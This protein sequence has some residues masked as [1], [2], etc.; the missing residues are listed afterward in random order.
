MFNTYCLFF[1]RS[2]FPL[3]AAAARHRRGTAVH[4]VMSCSFLF[5][6]QLT[7]P[8]TISLMAQKTFCETPVAA[9][10]LAQVHRATTHDGR[11]VAVKVQYLDMHERFD[12]DFVTMIALMDAATYLFKE[13][14][15]GFV[16][17]SSLAVVNHRLHSLSITYS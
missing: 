12:G 7:H 3:F 1:S 13:F 5:A 2:V 6:S 15:F 10:S 16:G 8:P 9:A 14:N 4:L 17:L 11:D